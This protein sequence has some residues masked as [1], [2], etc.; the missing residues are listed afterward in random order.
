[1]KSYIIRNSP[2]FHYR[3]CKRKSLVIKTPKK[4]ENTEKRLSICEEE[5]E[6][7]LVKVRAKYRVYN[8]PRFMSFLF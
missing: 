4:G 2:S 6:N 1:M 8:L 7:I 3:D 5:V